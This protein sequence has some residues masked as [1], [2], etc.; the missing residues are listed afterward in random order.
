MYVAARFGG[1]YDEVMARRR[2]QFGLQL[3]FVAVAIVALGIWAT[4]K[5]AEWYTTMPLTSAIRSF[6]ARNAGNQR[7]QPNLSESEVIASVKTQL[8]VIGRQDDARVTCDY[9]V[10]TGRIPRSASFSFTKSQVQSAAGCDWKT[11][12]HLDVVTTKNRHCSIPIREVSG[13]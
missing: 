1:R 8:P 5:V 2:L 4:Q 13:P 11:M 12:V 7:L 9:I 6:N 10:R 3:L